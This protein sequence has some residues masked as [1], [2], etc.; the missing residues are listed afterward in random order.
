MPI[1]LPPESAA[2]ERDPSV[3]GTFPPAAGEMAPVECE[4]MGRLAPWL[5]VGE[6][7][8]VTEVNIIWGP[9]IRLRLWS[10]LY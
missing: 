6:N 5:T 3:R 2:R 7:S 9:G 1:H 4:K 10:I 8:E